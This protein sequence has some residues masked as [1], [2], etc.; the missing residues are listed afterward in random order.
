MREFLTTPLG[1]ATVAITLGLL[2][3][4]YPPG[5]ALLAASSLLT[6]G[7]LRLAVAFRPA[8][9]PTTLTFWRNDHDAQPAGTAIDLDAGGDRR[10]P[11]R[12]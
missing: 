6:F 5:V 12:P 8:N 10:F 11:P 1:Q 4:A 3:V 7:F 9:R 2:L